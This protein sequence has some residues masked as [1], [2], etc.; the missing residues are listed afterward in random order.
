[1]TTELVASLN[2]LAG[3]TGKTD[4]EAANIWAGIAKPYDELVGALNRK[5]GNKLPGYLEMDGVCNQLASTS[6]LAGQEAL[7]RFAA[8]GAH[9]T[10]ASITGTWAAQ[11]KTWSAI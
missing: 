7:S 8:T 10:W 4:V 2:T 11:T 5:A 3:T 1:M 6:G 9:A